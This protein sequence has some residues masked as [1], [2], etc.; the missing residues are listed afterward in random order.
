[1]EGGPDTDVIPTVF[2]W[3][4]GGQ[5]VYISGTFTGWKKIPMVKR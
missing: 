3:D 5:D 1:M 2:K 4:G